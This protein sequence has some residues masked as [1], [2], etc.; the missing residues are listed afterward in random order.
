M[1]KRREN[2]P[3]DENILQKTCHLTRILGSALLEFVDVC[4][5]QLWLQAFPALFVMEKTVMKKGWT[6]S[7]FPDQ[8]ST[9]TLTWQVP[10]A[11]RAKLVVIDVAVSDEAAIV[12]VIVV[13]GRSEQRSVPRQ[14]QM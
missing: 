6:S 13:V 9:S 10:V 12:E 11:Q 5:C 7:E 4:I 14:R 3:H 2:C 8:G 1:C